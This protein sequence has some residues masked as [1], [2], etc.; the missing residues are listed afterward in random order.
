MEYIQGRRAPECIFHN[1]YKTGYNLF[2]SDSAVSCVADML[3]SDLEI[4]IL[5]SISLHCIEESLISRLAVVEF[6]WDK[7][8]LVANF[9]RILSWIIFTDLMLQMFRLISPQTVCAVYPDTQTV[10]TTQ[11]SIYV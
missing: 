5:C 4:Y 10:E 8:I 11:I 3:I 2:N 7:W 1:Q 9:F 6:R